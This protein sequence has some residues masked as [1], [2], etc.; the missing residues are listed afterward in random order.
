MNSA[1]KR[2]I[3][4]I[5]KRWKIEQA[6]LTHFIIPI[7]FSGSHSGYSLEESDL[8]NFILVNNKNK[9]RTYFRLTLGNK[10]DVQVHINK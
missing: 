8:H 6:K 5:S 2:N 10:L 4:S 3:P 7:S 1:N 9:E